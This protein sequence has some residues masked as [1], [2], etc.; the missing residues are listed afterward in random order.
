VITEYV[1]DRPQ[2]LNQAFAAMAITA[3]MVEFPCARLI[4]IA[5][6]NAEQER[7]RGEAAMARLCADRHDRR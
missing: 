7:Q 6:V 4:S 2:L 3:L 1:N 5:A